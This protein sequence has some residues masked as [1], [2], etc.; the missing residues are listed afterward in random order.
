M[1]L[2]VALNVTYM[3]LCGCT[4]GVLLV[5]TGYNLYILRDMYSFNSFVNIL[6]IL[7]I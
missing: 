5:L 4:E 1:K 2:S 6:G 7:F 3:D